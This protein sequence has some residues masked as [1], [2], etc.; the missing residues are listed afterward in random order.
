ML[1][2]GLALSST[3]R[4]LR[5][6]ANMKKIFETEGDEYQDY[7]SKNPIHSL[8]R[9]AVGVTVCTEEDYELPLM[10]YSVNRYQM[11]AAIKELGILGSGYVFTENEIIRD[12]PQVAISLS[13]LNNEE[14][15]NLFFLA[16]RQ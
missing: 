8:L 5:R 10:P 15:D 7:I 6:V 4:L 12:N 13:S 2:I 1:Q 11:N 14:I 9:H 3:A 16:A